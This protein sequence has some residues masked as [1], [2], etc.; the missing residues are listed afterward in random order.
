M[1]IPVLNFI[2]HSLKIKLILFIV[3]PISFAILF[4]SCSEKNK[5]NVK[6]VVVGVSSD[7]S[8]I[9]P[10]FAFNILEGH[11]SDLL[12]MKPANEIWN[13]ETGLIE[14]SPMLAESW[15]INTD[16]NFV[17]LNLKR[18]IYWSDGEK[19]TVDDIVYSF[20][21]Y[22]DPEVDS[23]MLGQ[24][25]NFYLIDDLRIDTEKTFKIISANSLNIYFKDAKYFSFLDINLPILPKHVFKNIPLKDIAT[26]EINFKP[27]TN[28]PF[29]LYKWE[30]DLTIHL[31]ADSSSFL[32]NPD[33]PQEI[34][35]KIIP[36]PNSMITQ[37][38][39]GE[40]DIAE[41]INSDK[42]KELMENEN[43][44]ISSIKGRDYDYIGWNHL[45]PTAF[46]NKNNKA[47]IFFGSA[48][49]RTA[50]SHAINREEILNTVVGE[51][52]SLCKS[53]VS[54]IFKSYYDSDIS[55]NDY[56]P[57]LAKE[58]LAENG[59]IDKNGNG[60][61]EKNN[62]E[63]SFDMYTNSGNARREF[64]STIIKNNLKAVGID[65]N[66]KIVERGELIDGLLS[67]KFDSWLSGWTIEIPLQLNPYWSSDTESGMLNFSSFN[68]AELD[69]LLNVIYPATPEQ[70]KISVYKKIQQIFS[71]KE[72]VTFLY[73]SDNIVAY[74]KKISNLKL[75][76]LGLF[77]NCWEWEIE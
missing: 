45:D 62:L 38:K 63:F 77:H 29:K 33:G 70:E 69:S 68:N 40:I 48:E 53:P 67:R 25:N 23:R 12:F 59:W 21:L 1:R 50:L 41:Q 30:R 61:V 2:N 42:V 10:L 15:R 66:I 54:P 58:I 39:K 74:N 22:S 46:S 17:Q 14:F 34:V 6:R 28:G 37:L 65:V 76:P 16:S 44:S 24:F 8:T 52:G 18:N 19:I 75:S 72:P 26:S 36:D 35:F 7:V 55:F 71:D 3:I 64:A 20:E 31:K 49:V 47:N 60:I 5:T 4:S 32:F 13:D 56:N 27:V 57:V 73:W 9:N 43:V 11:L 51:Y